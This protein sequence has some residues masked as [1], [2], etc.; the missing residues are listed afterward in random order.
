MA[1]DWWIADAKTKLEQKY[2]ENNYL[3]NCMLPG[4]HEKIS[5][6]VKVLSWSIEQRNQTN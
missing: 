2:R 3:Y 6:S 1:L 5:L 4:Y